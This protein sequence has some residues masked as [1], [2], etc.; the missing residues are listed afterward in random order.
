VLVCKGF[1][2]LCI[3]SSNSFTQQLLYKLKKISFAK[4]L[5]PFKRSDTLFK[6]EKWNN[7]VTE[8]HLLGINMMSGPSF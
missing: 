3:I 8:C 1:A 7:K 6:H 5:L 4:N 2:R